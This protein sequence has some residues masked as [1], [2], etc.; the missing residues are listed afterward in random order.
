MNHFKIKGRYLFD[1]SIDHLCS[2]SLKSVTFGLNC[3]KTNKYITTQINNLKGESPPNVIKS[4]AQSMSNSWVLKL[5]KLE[6]SWIISSY[7]WEVKLPVQIS[8]Q[9]DPVSPKLCYKSVFLYMFLRLV[10]S[11]SSMRPGPQKPFLLLIHPCQHHI[12]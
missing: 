11:Q 5:S 6:P 12:N 2:S 7:C 3:S 8:T 9:Y 1:E 4:P 10:F